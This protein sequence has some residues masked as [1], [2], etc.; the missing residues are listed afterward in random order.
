MSRAS[1]E[2]H[3]CINNS[4][5]QLE[6]ETGECLADHQ[7]RISN[8]ANPTASAVA[9]TMCMHQALEKNGGRLERCAKVNLG[10]M[11]RCLSEYAAC[12]VRKMIGA[13]G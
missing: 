2:K 12:L 11:A 9:T 1:S 7:R 8:G 4:N 5:G 6:D 10:D 13:L 3:E